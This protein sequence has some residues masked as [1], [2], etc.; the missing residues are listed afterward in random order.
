M[1]IV[2]C[3]FLKK[4]IGT[5]CVE[6]SRSALQFVSK[7]YFSFKNKLIISR[8]LTFSIELW[9]Q[10]NFVCLGLQFVFM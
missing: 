1:F 7:W 3:T 4:T 9:M 5:S 2:L 6:Y 8:I 10:K